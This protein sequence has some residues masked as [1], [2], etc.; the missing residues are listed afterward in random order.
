MIKTDPIAAITSLKLFCLKARFLGD[1][2]ICLLLDIQHSHVQRRCICQNWHLENAG[3]GFFVV[4]KYGVFKLQ[5][6]C[7]ELK[8]HVKKMQ[9]KTESSYAHS[10]I[11]LD[12]QD[13]IISFLE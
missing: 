6:F 7:A 13:S 12:D 3:L 11:L 4:F 2:L 10:G 1:L 5:E 8:H 9:L